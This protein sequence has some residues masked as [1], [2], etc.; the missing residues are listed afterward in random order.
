[1]MN[2]KHYDAWQDAKTQGERKAAVAEH[3]RYLDEKIFAAFEFLAAFGYAGPEIAHH[4]MDNVKEDAAY[5]EDCP[6][7]DAVYRHPRSRTL[8]VTAGLHHA[9]AE[10][11]ITVTN[12]DTEDYFT[13]DG[14]RRYAKR[15]DTGIEYFETQ[16]NVTEELCDYVFR[17]VK[18]DFFGPLKA[19]IQGGEWLEITPKDFQIWVKGIDESKNSDRM[20]EAELQRERAA[21][22]AKAPPARSFPPTDGCGTP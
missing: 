20:K 8:T 22:E 12:T 18:E 4:N 13:Y 6:R 14:Y 10:L 7:T 5:Y 3:I 21:E 17:A 19:V 2:D 15:R 9:M 11:K 16:A 1:M